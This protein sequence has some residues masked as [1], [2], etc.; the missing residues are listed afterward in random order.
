MYRIRSE[1]M[2]PQTVIKLTAGDE[3]ITMQLAPLAKKERS[4]EEKEPTAPTTW[5]QM[6]KRTLGSQQPG[7]QVP[8][9]VSPM[10]PPVVA[11]KV[12][13]AK[14]VQ[15]SDGHMDTSSNESECA[16]DEFGDELP[17]D[18]LPEFS[19]SSVTS[20]PPKRCKV[21]RQPQGIR[22]SKNTR[23]KR[24]EQEVLHM[25]KTLAELVRRLDGGASHSNQ[26]H[27]F[28]TVPPIAPVAPAPSLHRSCRY[29]SVN[30][31]QMRST[32]S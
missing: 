1:E 13:P 31:V 19:S 23:V 18:F 12:E 22:M 21:R 3:V 11:K 24:V 20:R 4:K 15:M 14:H 29:A 9:R 30:R 8:S 5:A 25:Q 16:T 6:A 28:D 32:S 2:P 17:L 27:R 10:E 7:Q 26:M